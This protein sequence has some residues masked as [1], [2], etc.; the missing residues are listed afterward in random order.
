MKKFLSRFLNIFILS[1]VACAIWLMFVVKLNSLYVGSFG[2]AMVG[3][4]YL[5]G[6]LLARKS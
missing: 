6:V 5:F 1:A 4:A 2:A 3:G